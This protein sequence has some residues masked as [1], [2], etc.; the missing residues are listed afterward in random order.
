[1]RPTQK[2]DVPHQGDAIDLAIAQCTQW[3]LELSKRQTGQRPDVPR[4][5]E[6]VGLAQPGEGAAMGGIPGEGMEKKKDAG[7][8]QWQIET[9]KP[10]RVRRPR[11]RDAAIKVDA[12]DL[13]QPGEG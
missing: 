7:L 2:R 8:A 9:P 13:A 6:A 3:Q 1:M 5:V 11:Q 4:K 10:Q 12:V